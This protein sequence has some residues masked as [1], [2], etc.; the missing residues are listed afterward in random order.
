MIIF[1]M[2]VYY[3]HRL[4]WF[5]QTGGWPKDEIDHKNGIPSDNR[6]KNLREAT[7]S[8]QLHN[9]RMRSDNT[10]GYKGVCWAKKEG[11]WL[12]SITLHGKSKFIGYYETPKKAHAAYCAAAKRLHGEFARTK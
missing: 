3:A 12:A 4:A 6:W 11:R 2:R 5:Y 7:R 9:T 8:N 10:S 1:E